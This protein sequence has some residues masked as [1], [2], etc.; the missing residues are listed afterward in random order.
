MDYEDEM[1]YKKKV[2]AYAVRAVNER[3]KQGNGMR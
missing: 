1:E 3:N 2:F